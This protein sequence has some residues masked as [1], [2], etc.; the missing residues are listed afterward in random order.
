MTTSKLENDIRL[1]VTERQCRFADATSTPVCRYPDNPRLD[2][3]DWQVVGSEALSIDASHRGGCGQEETGARRS[4][5]RESPGPRI[6]DALPA[7][8]MSPCR[9]CATTPKLT[10][11]SETNSLVIRCRFP[12]IGTRR[13]ILRV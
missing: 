2:D 1:S 11:L 6:F 13:H 12:I 5:P 8:S 4:A 10:Y 3:N 7:T 9:D